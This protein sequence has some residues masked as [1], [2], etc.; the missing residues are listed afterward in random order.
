MYENLKLL[1]IVSHGCPQIEYATAVLFF[2]V[3]LPLQSVLRI[4][5]N[6][7]STD[8]H[9]DAELN[10]LTSEGICQVS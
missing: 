10:F 9:V 3:K 5:V 4:T 1:V 7:Y 2:V 8:I 6:R